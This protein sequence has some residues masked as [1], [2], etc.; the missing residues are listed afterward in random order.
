MAAQ[1]SKL[2]KVFGGITPAIVRAEVHR[3]AHGI[4][5]EELERRGIK[6][7]VQLHD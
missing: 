3:Q 4:I 7:D 1:Q 2:G 5:R 6:A